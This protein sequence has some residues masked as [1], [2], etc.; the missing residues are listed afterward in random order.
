MQVYDGRFDKKALPTKHTVAVVSSN[1]IICGANDQ[2]TIRKNGRKDWS[3][4]YCEAGKLCFEDCILEP[5]QVWIYAPNVP[6]KYTMYGKDETIYH[7]LHFT[8]SDVAD[9][10]SSLGI[11]LSSPLETKSDAIL[12]VLKNIQNSLTYDDE[13]SKLTAEY[14]TLFLFSLLVRHRT[15]F[16]E[17]NMMKRV[18]DNMEHSFSAP[19]DASHY[20]NMFRISVSRFN[21]LFKQ[22]VGIP[23]YA[24]YV[25][26]RMAN[27]C[28]L[29][30]ATSLKIQDIAGKC[31]YED[32]MYFAQVFKKNVGLTP[33]NYRRLNK[34][35]K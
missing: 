24:Y 1:R 13:L 5:G 31:G 7:Y 35:F 30:E 32:S 27:A 22:C 19:Y 9:L 34:A 14:H 16:S 12:N 11:T 33:S 21:H 3:L 20:A 8:G 28:N 23:P 17:T 4:F 18:T 25:R 2:M 29:L 6:Q 15:R 26:L 10:F